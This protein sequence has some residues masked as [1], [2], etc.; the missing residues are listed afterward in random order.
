MEVWRPRES[1]GFRGQHLSASVGFRAAGGWRRLDDGQMAARLR[2]AADVVAPRGC[3]KVAVE[4]LLRFWAR[5]PCNNQAPETR[6]APMDKYIG[7]DVHAASCTIAG[8]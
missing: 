6:R 2:P 8:A 3:S 5:L 4:S 1:H 7:I